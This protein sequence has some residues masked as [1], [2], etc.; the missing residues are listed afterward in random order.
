MQ[1]KA[2]VHRRLKVDCGEVM[3]VQFLKGTIVAGLAKM[4]LEHAISQFQALRGDRV[5]AVFAE[6]TVEVCA[7]V[8]CSPA[9]DFA[10]AAEEDLE[11]VDHVG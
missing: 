3:E 1:E 10:L 5:H 2:S 8:E 7:F 6:V 9:P 11:G 4:A